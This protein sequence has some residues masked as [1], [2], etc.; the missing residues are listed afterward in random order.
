MPE[1]SITIVGSYNVGLF[2]KGDR[3]PSVGETVIGNKF[4]EG[5]GGKGSN[6]AVAASRLG[7][8]TRF[9]GRIGNDK[10]GQDA[11]AMYQQLGISTDAIK[12]DTG[13]H[14]GIS[15]IIIDKDGHNLISVVPGANFNLSQEDID[16]A[17]KAFADSYIV[18][19]QLEN[20]LEVI[21][22]AI[23]KAHS[24]GAR[25]LLD[26]APAVK[27]PDDLYPCIDYIK[28]NETEAA[29]LTDIQVTDVK[30]A[31]RAGKWFIERGV[32]TA[33]IT[34]GAQGS[35]L[36]ADGKSKHF[37]PPQVKAIDSTG[38]GDVF[39]GA[40]IAALS[41]EKKIEDA[42]VFANHAAALSVTR[43]G[44]IE[45]IPELKEVVAFLDSTG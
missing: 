32:K 34:L 18:G 35:V 2:L 20:K 8:K 31:E 15:V 9:I 23:R 45:S 4:H 28:P 6:Q 29:I 19:F 7:A 13:I 24:L 10:Y 41:Q 21:D 44:V 16:A 40:L 3:L 36:I 5:G 37:R 22:Y 33:I 25:T 43:L 39:S 17:E 26:P 27:I 14:S 30:S 42:I 38:A 12:V 1:K 11:L